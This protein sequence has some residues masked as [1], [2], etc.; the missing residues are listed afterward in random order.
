[1]QEYSYFLA[2]SYTIVTARSQA[3]QLM[4]LFPVLKVAEKIGKTIKLRADSMLVKC[5]EACTPDPGSGS[6]LIKPNNRR[7]GREPLVSTPLQGT[8]MRFKLFGLALAFAAMSAH[9]ETNHEFCFSRANFIKNLAKERD[10]GE[11]KMEA[12]DRVQKI[13]AAHPELADDNSIENQIDLVYKFKDYKPGDFADTFYEACME[14][15]AGDSNAK[16]SK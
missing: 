1:M 13:K 4:Q 16:K 8:P 10:A 3:N 5:S 11:L 6:G 7:Q 14:K 9:A 2:R 15:R 12:L